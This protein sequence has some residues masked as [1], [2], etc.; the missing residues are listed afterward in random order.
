MNR[1]NTEQLAPHQAYNARKAG[2]N[3]ANRVNRTTMAGK[4]LALMLASFGIAACYAEARGG[5]VECRNVPR[6][7]SDAEVCRTRCG[8]EGCRTR[9]AEQERY[10]RAHRCW[11]D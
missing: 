9:C 4:I 3:R 8:D 2:V 11:V 7:R 1:A 6:R 5:E 10:S